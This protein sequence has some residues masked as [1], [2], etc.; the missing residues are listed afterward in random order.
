MFEIA[1][2]YFGMLTEK[3]GKSTEKIRVENQLSI[4]SLNQLLLEKYQGLKNT[5]YKIALNNKFVDRQQ[6]ITSN[7]EVSLL[8]PFS[9]G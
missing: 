8:P 2:H 9:G 5:N 6:L 7:A 4:E 3:T 1:I